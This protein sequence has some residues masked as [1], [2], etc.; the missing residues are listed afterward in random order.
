VSRRKSRELAL[1][2]LFHVDVGRSD[3]ETALFQAFA[4]EN[5][6]DT[7]ADPLNE[8]DAL[9]ARDLVQG[10]WER[11]EHLDAVIAQYAKDWVVDRMPGVDRNILRMAL[12]ELNHQTDVPQSV[13]ADEAV[14][15]AKT[16]STAESSK[17][18]NGILGS[19]IR[20]M[21]QGTASVE[22]TISGN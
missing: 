21:K 5:D 20:G 17:F 2:V 19:V 18:I 14:E 12:Y 3:A 22:Q 8:K 9:Y 4:R 10:T 11:R 13:V 7:G 15:L 1:Q 6:G 16:F